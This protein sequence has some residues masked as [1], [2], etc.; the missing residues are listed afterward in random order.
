MIKMGLFGKNSEI[1]QT[2]PVT[3]GKYSELENKLLSGDWQGVQNEAKLLLANDKSD[4]IAETMLVISDW[5]LLG[6]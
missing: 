3:A 6:F 4:P 2:A 5:F 1:K